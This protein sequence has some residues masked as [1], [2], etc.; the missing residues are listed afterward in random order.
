MESSTQS[1]LS[2]IAISTVFMKMYLKQYKGVLM[3]LAFMTL[4]C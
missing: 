1:L 2:V 4:G 3:Q